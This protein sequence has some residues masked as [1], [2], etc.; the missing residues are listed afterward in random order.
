MTEST[1][2]ERKPIAIVN[3]KPPLFLDTHGILFPLRGSFGDYSIPILSRFTPLW[4]DDTKC[5]QI[6][7]KSL[8]SAKQF[9]QFLLDENQIFYKNISELRLNTD[10]DFEIILLDQPTKVVLGKKQITE[11][12]KILLNFNEQ[13]HVY[14]K[15]ITDFKN[16]DL[17]F[18]SQII[19]KEWI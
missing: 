4:N 5:R 9:L 16:L 6:Q 11:K 19:A 15:R 8:N 2:Y 1:S 12:I 14:Q 13:L 10:D 18:N 7:S 17:R 3:F